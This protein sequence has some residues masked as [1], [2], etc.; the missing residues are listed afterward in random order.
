MAGVAGCAPQHQHSQ[1]AEGQAAPWGLAAA[2]GRNVKLPSPAERAGCCE[3]NLLPQL[4]K[5]A[6]QTC[7]KEQQLERQNLPSS[8]AEIPLSG[9]GQLSPA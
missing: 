4:G 9:L 5:V 8:A 1:P 3:E 6:M 7:L 2:L